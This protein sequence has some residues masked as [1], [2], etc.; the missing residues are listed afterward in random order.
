MKADD[1]AM[2]KDWIGDLVAMLD[3]HLEEKLEDDGQL[4]VKL[5]RLLANISMNSENGTEIAGMIELEGLIKL[6]G[7]KL[8]YNA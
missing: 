5:V 8:I 4:L 6:F 1:C 3:M 7:I 2:L